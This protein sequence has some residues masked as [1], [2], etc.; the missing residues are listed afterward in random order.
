MKITKESKN[1][2]VIEFVCENCGTEFNADRGEYTQVIREETDDLGW[3]RGFLGFATSTAVFQKTPSFIITVQCPSCKNK[4]EKHI[5]TGE[6]PY[7]KE[8]VFCIMD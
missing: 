5:P 1:L 6:K 7:L 8:E 2:G 4:V 3:K